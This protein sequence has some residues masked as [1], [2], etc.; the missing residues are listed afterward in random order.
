MAKAQTK[1]SLPFI[2]SDLVFTGKFQMVH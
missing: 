2:I 1:L